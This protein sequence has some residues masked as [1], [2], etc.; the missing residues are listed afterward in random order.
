MG[1]T[2]DWKR[3]GITLKNLANKATDRSRRRLRTQGEEIRRAIINHIDN[4][5]LNWTPLSPITIR[6]KKGDSRIYIET[7]EFKSKIVVRGIKSTKSQSTIFIGANP[8][9]MHNGSKMKM[10]TLLNI[11]EY[12]NKYI[13]PRPLIRPTWEE[14]KP[15][16]ETTFR[17]GFIEDMKGLIR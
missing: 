4:Q 16:V 2:G 9:T 7:G 5:D 10:S 17:K 11:L 1:L 13:P 3:A 14:M 8:W 15:K 6:L 12:G